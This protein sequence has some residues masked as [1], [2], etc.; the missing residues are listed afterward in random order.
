M[1]GSQFTLGGT[2]NFDY[3]VGLAQ[4][5]QNFIGS[6]GHARICIMPDRSWGIETENVY[7]TQE[8]LESLLKEKKAA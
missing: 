6:S 1:I 7:I 8:I 5:V 3:A 4:R 2:F